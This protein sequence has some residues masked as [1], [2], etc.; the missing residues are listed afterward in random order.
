MSTEHPDDDE[1]RAFIAEVGRTGRP[2]DD[3]TW[4]HAMSLTIDVGGRRKPLA[5][6]T[7]FEIE[8]W[9]D[10]RWARHVADAN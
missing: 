5:E 6:C 9:G 2:P 1:V 7:A 4:R 10:R 3:E 8:G